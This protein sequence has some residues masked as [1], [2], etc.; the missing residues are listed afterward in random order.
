MAKTR[1]EHHPDPVLESGMDY[2]EHEKTYNGFITAVKWSVYGT[3][4]LM[5]ILY[6]VINP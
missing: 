4:V 6:F 1:P 5:I 3:A 2:A